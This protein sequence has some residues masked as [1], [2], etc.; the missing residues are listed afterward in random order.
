MSRGSDMTTTVR[1]PFPLS[2]TRVFSLWIQS[3]T[4]FHCTYLCLVPSPT[5]QTTHPKQTLPSSRS[6][7][8]LDL[9]PRNRAF[10]YPELNLLGLSEESPFDV[11]FEVMESPLTNLG[12]TVLSLQ[13]EPRSVVVT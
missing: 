11:R 10:V 2:T 5:L 8:F 4:P 13:R 1:N 3:T 12:F 7:V 6:E 9:K